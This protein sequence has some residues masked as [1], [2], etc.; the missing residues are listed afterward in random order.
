MTTM[1]LLEVASYVPPRQLDTAHF[2]RAQQPEE[3]ARDHR[4][5]RPPRYRRHVAR[6]ESAADMAER[7]SHALAERIGWDQLRS[8][9]A[10]LTNVHLPDL[11]F[12]GCGA[13]LAHRLGA[14]P[15]WV[16]DSHNGGC[17]SLVHLL[18]LAQ[19]LIDSGQI[20]DALLCNVQNTAG[21]VMG[22]PEVMKLPEAAIPGDGVGVSYVAASGASPVLGVETRYHGEFAA[23]AGLRLDDGRKYWEPGTSQMHLDFSPDKVTEIIRRGSRLVPEAVQAL[24]DRLG[25]KLS[26]VDLLITNQP[27]RFFLQHWSRQLELGPDRHLETFDLYGNLM[28]AAMTINL[29]HGLEQGRVSDGDLLMFGGF[30][31]AGDFSG[32]A[33]VRWRA[34]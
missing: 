21:T 33:A 17:A 18:G 16:L 6:E 11:P 9:D 15:D 24:V 30:A 26:E 23:D 8:V 34:G 29:E 27:N 7:A 14:R 13:E 5:F 28:G 3:E 19:A 12:T 2:L 10:V 25:L 20:R 1:S 4:M 31:H 32:A 22:Q